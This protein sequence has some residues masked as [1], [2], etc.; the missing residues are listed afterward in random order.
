[1][2]IYHVTNRESRLHTQDR[3]I[4][5]NLTKELPVEWKYWTVDQQG[6][7]LNENAEFISDSF[8]DVELE[9]MEEDTIHIEKDELQGDL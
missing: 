3:Y 7:W 2:T 8:S 4:V 9:D 1:M 5:Y 6:H